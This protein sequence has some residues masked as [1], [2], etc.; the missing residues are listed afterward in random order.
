MVHQSVYQWRSG[1][2]VNGGS[3]VSRMVEKRKRYADIEWLDK[4]K[5]RYFFCACSLFF[6]HSMLPILCCA[7]FSNFFFDFF[8]YC[9]Q[10]LLLAFHY[11]CSCS[12][13]KNVA[14]TYYRYCCYSL[15]FESANCTSLSTRLFSRH[16]LRNFAFYFLVVPSVILL[17]LL[18]VARSPI[19]TL[20]H[21]L[22]E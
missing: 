7:Y 1:T 11:C 2:V 10:Q 15:L 8:V 13:L 16:R 19:L 22:H 18:L 9:L 14:T 5:I 20:Y 6:L 4:H 12:Y 21:W 3:G 17:L